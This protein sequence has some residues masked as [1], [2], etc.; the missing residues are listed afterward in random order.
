M[1]NQQLASLGQNISCE[2]LINQC[3]KHGDVEVS[4]IQLFGKERIGNCPLCEKE[5]LEFKDNEKKEREERNK[6]YRLQ[7]LLRQSAIPPKF[8]TRTF[9]NYRTENEGQKKAL[10]LCKSMASN[11]NNCLAY[12]TSL[13]MSGK[14]GTGKNHLASAFAIEV[15]NQGKTALYTT[16]LRSVRLIK[17][18]YRKDSEMAEQDAINLFVT[19]DLLIIDEIGVQFGSDTEKMYLFE[20]INGRYENQKPTILLTNLSKTEINEYLGERIIDRLNEGGGGTLIFDWGSYRGKVSNDEN[21]PTVIHQ[22]SKS[23]YIEYL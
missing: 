7:E 15:M 22:E 1:A 20:I 5:R 23:K 9:E 19:P 16:V 3:E 12:G 8:L 14:P 10:E 11:F 17:S 21:L 2:K 18:T 13:L 4:V 6:A